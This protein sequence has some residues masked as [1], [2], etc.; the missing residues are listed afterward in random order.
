M[1]SLAQV[2]HI[3]KK[4]V[5]RSA[6]LL[7]GLS[8]LIAA[9]LTVGLPGSKWLGT[10]SFALPSLGLFPLVYIAIAA[11]VVQDDP[12]ASDLAF[13]PT[14]PIG[15]RP[16]LVSK[17]I[18]I[19]LVVVLAPALANT[20]YLARAVFD[21]P[22]IPLF[23]ESLQAQ[24]TFIAPIVLLAA[25]TR[26]FRGFV[27]LGILGWLALSIVMSWSTASLGYDPLTR[28][29]RESSFRV[30]IAL[31]T[32]GLLG[33]QYSRRRTHQTIGLTIAGV[34]A[35]SLFAYRTDIVLPAPPP[36]PSTEDLREVEAELYLVGL[37][38]QSVDG[39]NPDL[40]TYQGQLETYDLVPGARVRRTRTRI[41]GSDTAL[42]F[43]IEAH[44]WRDGSGPLY[45]LGMV[46]IEGIPWAG[47][48][49]EYPLPS[50]SLVAV[51]AEGAED[52]LGSSLQGGEVVEMALD[53]ELFEP[54]IQA[55]LPAEPG[56]RARV[57]DQVFTVRAVERSERGVRL[58]F[59][60]ERIRFPGEPYRPHWEGAQAAL[61]SPVYDEL[62]FT[63]QPGGHGSEADPVSLSQGPTLI[64]EQHEYPF[65][66]VPETSRWRDPLPADWFDVVEIVFI[67]AELVE[68]VR[69]RTEHT[70][71][72]WPSFERHVRVEDFP[73]R[74]GG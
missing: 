9:Y 73:R 5:R 58:L 1:S 21:E 18:L 52:E 38:S 34:M 67:D 54:R 49:D 31:L 39:S 40:V 59:D 68:T 26:S 33:F 2:L 14:R 32:L 13:W 44:P 51:V 56:A 19:G 69:V 7:C 60:S 27:T 50:A 23:T 6:V 42:E 57:R 12:P 65:S 8:L 22:W 20:V 29:M 45:A 30:G 16:L 43:S 11:I 63:M 25:I 15:A 37:Q 64:R 46:D 55:R 48:R 17:L 35:V 28:P 24:A 62:T 41:L 47:V 72:T 66:P 4:D 70:V 36:P 53:V 10:R 61:Y 3:L 74:R 71:P